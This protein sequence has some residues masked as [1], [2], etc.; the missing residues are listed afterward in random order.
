MRLPVILRIFKDDRLLEVKQFDTD[1]IVF[2]HDAEVNVEIPDAEVSSIHALIELRDAGYYL[3][4][5]GSRSGTFKNNQSILDEPLSSGDEIKVGPYKILFY[6]GAPKPKSI[7]V[8]EEKAFSPTPLKV[9]EVAK[10]EDV[11]EPKKV[12]VK[13]NE[14]KTGEPKE[15]PAVQEK[16]VKAVKVKIEKKSHKTFAPPSEVKDL[17]KYLKPNKG[18]A[19]EVTVAWKERILDSYRF[20]EKDK[21]IVIGSDAKAQVKLPSTVARSSQVIIEKALGTKI[22]VA[23]DTNIEVLTPNLNWGFDDLRQ[24]GRVQMVGQAAAIRLE[25]GELAAIS[26]SEDDIQVFVTHIPEMAPPKTLGWVDLSSGQLTGVILSLAFVFLLSLWVSVNAPET[27]E[28]VVDPLESKRVAQFIYKKVEPKQPELPVEPEK[29]PLPK[30]VKVE[31]QKQI[32]EKG[33]KVEL[34][35]KEDSAGRAQ[36]LRPKKGKDKSFSSTKKGGS[37]KLADKEGGGAKTKSVT[38]T[39]LFS[40]FGGGGV[41]ANPDKSYSGSGDIF[42]MASRA[43]GKSG[44][45]ENRA[46]DD[47]GSRFKDTGAGGKGFATEGIADIGTHGRSS[48]QSDYGDTGTGEKASVA[49]KAGGGEEEFLGSIDRE[50]VRRVV[51][52]GMRE[53]RS[54]YERQLNKNKGLEGRIVLAWVIAEQGKV[55]SA[56]VKNSNMNNKELEECMIGRLK[57]WRFPEPP[58]GGHPEVSFPFMLKA[59]K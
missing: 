39:G 34:A 45:A 50:A 37:V 12:E 41:R 35:K 13:K 20:G 18:P 25:Q 4:D 24:L 56:R 31:E 3:C 49:V 19:V 33:A 22:L 7:P 46:G 30:Q 48:G 43:T 23:A 10:S 17:K 16:P 5:L 27:A 8:Q 57:T 14:A 32:V 15:V 28:K 58:A 47:I 59:Q 53:I 9:I 42:G 54:C 44:T 38:E 36:E 1:Q 2:G 11:V 52:A 40:A 21:K 29:P 26:F 55:L 51:Q 6:V